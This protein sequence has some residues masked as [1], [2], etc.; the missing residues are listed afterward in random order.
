MAA[1]EEA[2][3]VAGKEEHRTAVEAEGST[4]E[5]AVADKPSVAEEEDRASVEAHT[6]SAEEAALEEV[7]RA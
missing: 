2:S 7:A 5:E 6:A 1:E 4:A 3:T